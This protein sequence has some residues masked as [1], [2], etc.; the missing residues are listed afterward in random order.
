MELRSELSK[1]YIA[2][3]LLMLMRTKDY[4]KISIQDVVD[5][6]GFSRMAYYRNFG[7]KDEVI[8]YHIDKITADFVSGSDIDLHIATRD[9]RQAL[10]MLFGHLYRHLELG[11]LLLKCG[12]LHLAQAAFDKYFLINAKDCD[13]GL[14]RLYVSGGAFRL[15][16]NWLETGAVYSPEQAASVISNF[17]K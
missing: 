11:K 3:A 9:M 10:T 15:Y 5:K 7:S 6:A 2:E 4:D 14:F 12:K 17:I 13:D 16:C 8:A 1:Q